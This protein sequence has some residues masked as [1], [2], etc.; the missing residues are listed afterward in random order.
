[1]SLCIT[2]S[3]NMQVRTKFLLLEFL[4]EPTTWHCY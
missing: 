1:L 4:W 3:N 2:W